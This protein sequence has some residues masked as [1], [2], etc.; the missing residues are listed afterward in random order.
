MS[1]GLDKKLGKL[2]AVPR[3]SPEQ[4]TTHLCRAER[5]A[6]ENYARIFAL[7]PASLLG[8]LLARELRSPRLRLLLE[9]D[10][11]P[12]RSRATKVTAHGRDLELRRGVAAMAADCGQSVSH[13]CAV[14]VRAELRDRWL[15]NV[16]MTRFES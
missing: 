11:P 16:W 3:R 15:E 9:T 14:L 4:I 2:G 10:V 8:L 6:F 7:D 13:V 12:N 5:T 1:I